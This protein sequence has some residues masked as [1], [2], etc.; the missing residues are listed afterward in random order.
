MF[1]PDAPSSKAVFAE[2]Q[3]EKLR[4]DILRYALWRTGSEADA[5]DLVADA[6]EWA[7]DPERK[8]WDARKISFFA[9]VRRVMDDIAVQRARRGHGRFEVVSSEIASDESTTDPAPLPDEAPDARRESA[10]LGRLG[11]RLMDRLTGRDAL[12]SRLF[13]VACEGAEEPAEQAAKIGCKVEDV[14]E[15]LRRLKYHGAIVMA[16]ARE[17]EAARMKALR[18]ATRAPS[19]RGQP[20]N[21]N[22]RSDP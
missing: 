9:H 19:T 16:E 14:Y 2:L 6:I 7:C 1:D 12:A 15:A 22:E 21:A 17:E 11:K 13:E 3:S 20:V 5:N 8:P 10:W 18:D 4:R